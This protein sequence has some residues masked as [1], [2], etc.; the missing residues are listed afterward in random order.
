VPN[1][2]SGNPAQ[3]QSYDEPN[4]ETSAANQ[5]L[6]MSKMA[7]YNLASNLGYNDPA[8]ESPKN[9]SGHVTASPEFFPTP[10]TSRSGQEPYHPNQSKPFRKLPLVDE[11]SRQGILELIHR[12]GPKTPDGS[13]ITGDHPLLALPVLQEY[14]DLYF[15]RFNVSYPLLHQATF[16]PAGVD[17]L[18]LISVLLLGA[19]YD[20][21]DSHLVA[22]CIVSRTC[23]ILYEAFPLH[24]KPV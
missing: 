19:T 18:L 16:E 9:H 17:P 4:P 22:V 6:A 13:E 1:T 5:I 24:V 3:P 15:R 11:Q 8:A 14:C 21:K 23:P 2:A 12:A 20:T 10:T 7:E